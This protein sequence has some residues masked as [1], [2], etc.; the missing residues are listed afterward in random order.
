[1]KLKYI[2][3]NRICNG[4]IIFEDDDIKIYRQEK[5]HIVK[6]DTYCNLEGLKKEWE[7]ID[8][9]SKLS[10]FIES[11]L[12]LLD[13]CNFYEMMVDDNFTDKDY[14]ECEEYLKTL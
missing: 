2:P 3:S 14:Q 9:P 10:I 13:K 8:K 11:A 1:M 4:Y 5:D 6:Q 12:R 7:V